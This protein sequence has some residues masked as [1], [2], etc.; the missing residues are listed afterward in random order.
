MLYEVIT[1]AALL[2]GFVGRIYCKCSRI[3]NHKTGAIGG[4]RGRCVKC[5]SVRIGAGNCNR[6]QYNVRMRQTGIDTYH[7]IAGVVE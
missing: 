4:E 3:P 6:N 1:K 7:Y 5:N 2:V